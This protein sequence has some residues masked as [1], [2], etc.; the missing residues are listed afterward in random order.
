M[1]TMV[2]RGRGII[3][4]I[5]VFLSVALPSECKEDWMMYLMQSLSFAIS[6]IICWILGSKWNKGQNHYSTMAGK[7]H[8]KDLFEVGLPESNSVLLPEESPSH[9]FTLIKVEYCGILLFIPS[10]ISLV[11]ALKP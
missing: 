10:L 1:G 9:S 8:W 5:L 4:P 11:L 3:V 2:W 6:G 7:F